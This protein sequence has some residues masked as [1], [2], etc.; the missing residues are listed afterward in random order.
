MYLKLIK[1]Q[2]CWNI[3]VNNFTYSKLSWKVYKDNKPK[4][5]ITNKTT[6]GQFKGTQ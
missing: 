4:V 2:D 1:N 6:P 5:S 3:L